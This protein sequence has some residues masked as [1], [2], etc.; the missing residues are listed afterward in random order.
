MFVHLQCLMNK[1]A[2]KEEGVKEEKRR[3]KNSITSHVVVL[4]GWRTRSSHIEQKC[5]KE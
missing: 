5:E 1:G 2:T 4:Y 3:E